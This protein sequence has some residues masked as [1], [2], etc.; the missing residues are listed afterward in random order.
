MSVDVRVLEEAYERDRSRYERLAIAVEERL[1][2][3][4]R[5]AG[6]RCVV[7]HRV[8]DMDSFIKKAIRKKY[9][10]SLREIGDRAGVRVVVS[11]EH[12]VQQVAVLVHELFAVVDEEDKHE[13][14]G[15]NE[16]GYL[17]HHLDVRLKPGSVAD[18]D[19]LGELL[20]EVQIHTKLQ[21]AWAEVSH[22][23]IYKSRPSPPRR[24]ER[25]ILRL[26]TLVEL[27]DE[28]VSRA[29]EEILDLPGKEAARLLDELDPYFYRLAG[30]DYDSELSL[31]IITTLA[32]LLDH[33]E[34]RRIGD[35]IERFVTK[36]EEKLQRLYDRHRDLHGVDELLLFQP[37]A[38]LVFERIEN[39]PFILEQEWSRHYPPD[40]LEQLALLWGK[41]Y[42]SVA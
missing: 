32:G 42:Q 2:Q 36:H 38:L 37:E 16:L 31:Q 28:E 12:H 14:L 13:T 22:E 40:L 23:L 17:G 4:T 29:Q 26:Q 7:S 5:A 33:D 6:T 19:D 21:S 9:A 25:R 39:D 1:A 41:P 15:A 20:C 27:F 10:D 3:A 11:Y 35:V 34:L 24:I 30:R 18:S 8:K